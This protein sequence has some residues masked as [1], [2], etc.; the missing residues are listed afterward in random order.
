MCL[1]IFRV[2]EWVGFY[3]NGSC[4]K[5]FRKQWVMLVSTAFYKIGGVFCNCRL[6]KY[7]C[8]H[9]S[10]VNLNIGRGTRLQHFAH[11]NSISICSHPTR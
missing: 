11:L 2:N 6:S 8:H 3:Q 10:K 4:D 7:T 5:Q 1:T 9:V